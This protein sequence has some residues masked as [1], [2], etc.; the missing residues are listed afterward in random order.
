[1]KRIKM[2]YTFGQNNS[3]GFYK[4]PAKF[5]IV[6][7][8]ADNDAAFLAASVAGMYTDGVSLGVDCY[9]CGDRWYGCSEEHDTL[10]DALGYVA[11]WDG[12]DK[13]VPQYVVVDAGDQV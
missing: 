5:I 6:E 4:E 8:A 10:D 11:N 9:C 7:N 3:G 2:I 12:T 1:M 13:S